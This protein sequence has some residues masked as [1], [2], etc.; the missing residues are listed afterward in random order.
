MKK[1]KVIYCIAIILI[2]ILNITKGFC[3][4][5]VIN[6]FNDG[7]ADGFQ[8]KNI[9]LI[10]NFVITLILFLTI[11]LI[12]L[13]K[14]NIMKYKKCMCLLIIILGSVFVP[15]VLKNYSGGIAGVIDAKTYFPLIVIWTI[16]I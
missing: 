14:D 4:G 13:R 6:T 1:Y 10:Y 3:S 2:L 15:I 9:F 8:G 5:F 12:T 16:M 7:F 11:I